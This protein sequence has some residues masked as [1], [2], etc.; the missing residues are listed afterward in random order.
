MRATR[1]SYFEAALFKILKAEV[2]VQLLL[3]VLFEVVEF[4]PRVTAFIALLKESTIP[5]EMGHIGIE[6]GEVPSIFAVA[7]TM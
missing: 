3:G 7:H 1:A 4:M 5:S 6:I 2:I